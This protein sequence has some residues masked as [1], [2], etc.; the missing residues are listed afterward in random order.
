MHQRPLKE[1]SLEI[2]LQQ[3][4]LFM[5]WTSRRDGPTLTSVGVS[6]FF[7]Q[8]WRNIYDC[9]QPNV[10]CCLNTSFSF[11]INSA[12]IYFNKSRN[13]NVHT[14]TTRIWV[15]SYF[16][17]RWDYVFCYMY[18][19]TFRLMKLIVKLAKHFSCQTI[20]D[21][22]HKNKYNMMLLDVKI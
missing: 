6:E 9:T 11:S 4:L 7:F 21:L 16:K 12:H 17:F 10:A 18:F 1:H 2:A 20:F 19:S 15:I 8:T 14:T 3:K 22:S 13:V 5:R